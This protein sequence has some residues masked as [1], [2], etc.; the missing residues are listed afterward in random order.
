MSSQRETNENKANENN[1][2]GVI[3]QELSQPTALQM[4]QNALQIQANTGSNTQVH[5]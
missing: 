2:E 5:S 4:S 3:R 1:L